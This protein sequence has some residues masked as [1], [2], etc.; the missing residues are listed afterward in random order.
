VVVGTT[1]DGS[2]R[3]TLIEFTPPDDVGHHPISPHRSGVSFG[4]E[5]S[6]RIEL[7]N[8]RTPGKIK[9]LKSLCPD[10][11]GTIGW[12]TDLGML[13]EDE[14][15]VSPLGQACGCL[16]SCRPRPHYNRIVHIRPFTATFFMQT[17]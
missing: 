2:L 6:G 10:E 11:A 12:Y 5:E 14:N 1:G 4:R 16:T 3:H 17:E 9:P 13:L 7:A 15:A 8:D